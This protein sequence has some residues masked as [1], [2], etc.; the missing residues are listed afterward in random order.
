MNE[1]PAASVELRAFTGL[2]TNEDP[3][4]LTPGQS[5]EQVNMMIVRKGVLESRK[6]S[7]VVSF[8]N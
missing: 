5:R 2:A 4:D 7:R 1:K 6:G 3:H 8:E